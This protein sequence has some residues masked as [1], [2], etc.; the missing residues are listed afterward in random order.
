MILRTIIA[1]KVTP[2]QTGFSSLGYEQFPLLVAC[3]LMIVAAFINY[4]TLAVPNTL[5]LTGILTAWAVALLLDTEFI[6]PTGGGVASVLVSMVLGAALLIPFYVTG[7]LGEGGV[8][9]QAAFGAWL[10]CALPIG[11]AAIMTAETTIAAA[12]LTILVG[13]V[14]RLIRRIRRTEPRALAL[15]QAQVTLSLGSV[16]ALGLLFKYVQ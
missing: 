7:W 12:L 15:S 6:P 1:V 2:S 16:V 5:S 13:L 9:M 4:Y 8:K 11:K 10:G 3:A 14:V